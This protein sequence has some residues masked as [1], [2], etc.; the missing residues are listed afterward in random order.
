[1]GI[2]A[3]TA[4]LFPFC[5]E[6]GRWRDSQSL[7]RASF[8]L[9]ESRQ[10]Q[11]VEASLLCLL[12]LGTELQRTGSLSSPFFLTSKNYFRTGVGAIA[13]LLCSEL[14]FAFVWFVHTV[15]NVV[16]GLHV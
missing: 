16:L 3:Q 6:N 2:R 10:C 15:A 8:L 11:R 5:S 4:P 12:P 9:G 1:M 14:V 7:S 13:M